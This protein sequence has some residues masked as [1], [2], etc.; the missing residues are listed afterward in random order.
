MSIDKSIGENAE[1]QNRDAK[2]EKRLL[3]IAVREY[4]ER[5]FKTDGKAFFKEFANGEAQNDRFKAFLRKREGYKT[6]AEKKK[7]SNELFSGDVNRV[8][9]HLD[10]L[11]KAVRNA[12]SLEFELT[13]GLNSK[14]VKPAEEFE[15][16]IKKLSLTELESLAK[17]PQDR[18]DFIGIVTKESPNKYR[19]GWAQY[20]SALQEKLKFGDSE[21]VLLENHIKNVRNFDD[22]EHAKKAFKSGSV[23]EDEIRTVLGFI[24]TP[25]AKRAIVKAFLPQISIA[26]LV[27]MKIFTRHEAE[28]ALYENLLKNGTSANS[29]SYG[30]INEIE[31]AEQ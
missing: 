7:Y 12:V 1:S 13:D 6:L 19:K 18:A 9:F 10:E 31:A 28:N 27:R 30:I 11:E 20:L 16:R 29:L 17:S 2:A 4:V 22:V 21:R 14:K 24:R 8:A 15:E 25:E 5:R 23:S 26:E 3:D